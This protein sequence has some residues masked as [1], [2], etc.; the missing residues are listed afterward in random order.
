MKTLLFFCIVFIS[1]CAPEMYYPTMQNIPAFE[2]K[3]QL[4]ANYSGS[5][6]G[7]NCQVGYALSDRIG[8]LLNVGSYSN[9]DAG[10]AYRAPANGKFIEAGAGYFKKK[11]YF[12]YEAYGFLAKGS[13]Y[14]G[15]GSFNGSPL[16]P[17]G[18]LTS[19]IF[20]IAVQPSIT[21]ARKYYEVS[22]STR[23]SFVNYYDISVAPYFFNGIDT[24]AFLRDNPTFHFIE[25]AATFRLGIK[26][27]KL[28]LQLIGSIPFDNIPSTDHF[29]YFEAMGYAG[30]FV[31]F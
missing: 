14:N 16:G 2:K 12:V 23:Y 27:V 13:I 21:Y 18:I 28:Q 15:P 6:A 4:V 11:N 17:E 9:D 26:N 20:R 29:Q 19:D 24:N 3:G 8:I 5:F 1:A 7:S 31:K 30:F 22:L 10:G 25:P